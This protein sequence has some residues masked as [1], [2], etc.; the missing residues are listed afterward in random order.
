MLFNRTWHF[1]VIGFFAV[2]G[3]KVQAQDCPPL[4]PP[5]DGSLSTPTVTV[6]TSVDVLCDSGFSLFGATPLVCLAG[7]TWSDVIGNCKQDCPVLTPPGN[8]RLSTSDVREGTSVDVICNTDYSLVGITPLN[9]QTGGTWSD[10]VGACQKVCPVLQEPA[11]GSLSTFAVSIGTTVDVDCDPG[12]TL[13]GEE[14]FFCQTGATWSNVVGICKQDCPALIEP[15]DG[16]LSTS[17]VSVG[18]SVD[19]SCDSSFTLFGTTPLTCLPGGTWSDVVGD[20]RKDCEDP[21]IS[22]GNFAGSKVVG[23]DATI[24]CEAGYVGGGTITC[25]ASSTWNT[26][27]TCDP[28]DCGPQTIANG[29]LMGDTVYSGTATVI[30]DTGYKVGGP[31]YCLISGSWKTPLPTCDPQDCGDPYIPYG[32]LSADSVTVY[33]GTATVECENGYQGGGTATC[34]SDGNWDTLPTCEPIDCGLPSISNGF[35]GASSSTL[36][37]GKATFECDVGYNGGG[38]ARCL[39]DGTW[40]TPPTC[41]PKDC[42][43]PTFSNGVLN[44]DTVFDGIATIECDAGYSGGGTATCLD[45]GIWATLP[46]CYPTDCGDPGDPNGELSGDSHYLGTGSIKCNTGYSGGGPVTCLNTGSWDTSAALPCSLVD[47][48]DP[49]DP[50]GVLV[51]DSLYSGTAYI[52]CDTGYTNGGTITCLASGHWNKSLAPACVLEDCGSLTAPANGDVNL[53][54]TTYGSSA[55]FSCGALYQLNGN[56]VLTCEA[57]G[58][59]S[60]LP[61]ICDDIDCPGLTAPTDGSLSSSAVS[62]GTSVDV[63]CNSGLSLFGTTPLICET[64][65]TWADA[66]G[67][68]KQDCPALTPPTYGTISTA[69]VK[70]GTSV[71]VKC[72]K[73]YTMFGEAA[74]E[75]LPGGIWNTSVPDCVRECGPLTDPPNGLVFQPDGTT[76]NDETTYTCN[77]GYYLSH[78]NSRVC[79]ADGSWSNTPAICVIYD[80]G[81]VL[82]PKNGGVTY[83][84]GT[85]YL[86]S[87]VYSCNIGYD[88]IGDANR[89]C[90]ANGTWDLTDPFCQIRD[91][92]IISG[93]GNGSVDTSSGTTYLSVAIFSCDLGYT[94]IGDATSTCQATELWNNAPPLCEIN[95]CGPLTSPTNGVVSYPATTYTETAAYSCDTG[96][97]VNGVTTRTCQANSTWSEVEP[98]CEKK[99]CGLIVVPA[100]G[101]VSY[102]NGVT[103]YQEVATFTCD[104][105]YDVTGTVTRTCLADGV[106]GD[107]SPVCVIKDCGPLSDPGNGVVDTSNG[108]TFGEV[109]TFFCDTGYSLIGDDQRDCQSDGLWGGTSPTCE[110]KD[111]GPLSDPADGLVTVTLTTYDE[112]ANYTCDAGYDLIGVQTR[113]CWQD[114]N[115]SDAEPSCQRKDCGLPPEID[116]GVYDIPDG[117]E[118]EDTAVYSCIVYYGI[119]GSAIVQCLDTGLWDTIPVCDIDCGSPISIENGNFTPPTSTLKNTEVT[120]VCNDG[121]EM[122]RQADITCQDNGTWTQA[123]GC[124]LESHGFNE[125]CVATVQCTTVKSTCRSADDGETRCLCNDTGEVYEPIVDKCLADCGPLVSPTDGL[126]LLPHITSEGQIAVYTCNN[127][128]ALKDANSGVRICLPTGQ[129]SGSDPLCE[130]GCQN[131]VPPIHGYVNTSLGTTAGQK[132]YYSCAPGYVLDGEE[133]RVCLK[134]ELTWDNANPVCAIE[135]PT[136]SAISHGNVDMSI[137]RREGAIVTY[138]CEK[139][140]A[141]VGEAIRKCLSTG[142]WKGVEPVCVIAIFPDIL[143]AI[144]AVLIFLVIVDILGILYCVYMKFIKKKKDKDLADDKKDLLNDSNTNQEL[145]NGMPALVTS[146]PARASFRN[147]AKEAG[148]ETFKNPIPDAPVLQQARSTLNR[149][150]R[151]EP[152]WNEGRH[153]EKAVDTTAYSSEPANYPDESYPFVPIVASQQPPNSYQHQYEAD[154]TEVKEPLN[155]LFE[156]SLLEQDVKTQVPAGKPIKTVRA[157]KSVSSHPSREEKRPT[158][159]MDD[160]PSVFKGRMSLPK[161]PDGVGWNNAGERL[162]SEESR[163][164]LKESVKTYSPTVANQ[165]PS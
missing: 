151:L 163:K 134:E 69:A 147:Q 89:T 159:K 22:N 131:P 29:N 43:R 10:P 104:P 73:G 99:D 14:Q 26:L 64:G 100:N 158:T 36:Y 85:T 161:V 160:A 4:T 46:L 146:G 123:P 27:P 96:Y 119:V 77:T 162:F 25:T 41:S 62:V 83:P 3:C 66:V 157:D 132:I 15:S 59:W 13:F 57:G 80:C 138:V 11:D 79:Q 156:S 127:G 121:Y 39:A 16:S 30:C 117:T 86:Q 40:E 106:W 108:T 116:H 33:E 81:N 101:G 124:R 44:G 18:T 63:L 139:D 74:L 70:E 5:T 110:I 7:G 24:L 120:Y 145:P 58:T 154:Q 84:N 111:C 35:L 21:G 126:V 45:T 90:Q 34:L 82:P 42:R 103:T 72:N 165:P 141:L 38:A 107:F 113:T 49:G 31:A 94:M 128:F 37:N 71:K 48:G 109:A 65:G 19:V 148:E 6:S 135:C 155:D 137:G 97:Y 55:T 152:F 115:W 54:T 56:P 67:I 91:C 8:G 75:C 51:G 32:R 28:I 112:M 102:S 47:C 129:W 98:T 136:L 1:F 125:I 142:K 114:G 93:P 88:L 95:D 12:F 153:A 105:G 150:T 87:A 9:C 76:L 50:N 78:T 118:Y 149:P 164:Y 68:C 140:Y 2:F 92:G 20:C 17:K 130:A 23:Q 53:A 61:P 143:L 52:S 122:I 144:G 133:E 60:S